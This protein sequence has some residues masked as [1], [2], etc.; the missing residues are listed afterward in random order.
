[1]MSKI[2]RIFTAAKTSYVPEINKN[3][4]MACAKTYFYTIETVQSMHVMY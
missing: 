4:F 2:N 1:M 3:M